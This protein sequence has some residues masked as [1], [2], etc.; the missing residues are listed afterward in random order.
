MNW[1]TVAP[2]LDQFLNY[3]RSW[4]RSDV[5]A[6]L[7][8]AA[9]MVP[10]VMANATIAGLSPVVGLWASLLP[11]LVYAALGTSRLLS[12]GPDSTLALMTASALAPWAAGDPA[13]YAVL[14]AMLAILVGVFCLLGGL[15]KLGVLSDLLSRPVLVGFMTGV[16]CIMISS[17]FGKLTGAPVEGESF[18][19]QVWSL[20]EKHRQMHWPTLVMAMAILAALLLM[21]R[22]FPRF[23]GALIVVL[24]ST[25]IVAVF[26]LEKYGINV[27]GYV[28]AGLPS[29][30]F[31]AVS[32]HELQVLAGAA[33]GLSIV[34]FSETSLTARIFSAKNREVV[35]PNAELRALGV[36]NLAAGLT[37]GLA[38]GS[39]SSRTALAASTGARSQMFSLFALIGILVVIL[40]ANR[41][42]EAFPVAALGALVVYAALYL[43][44]LTEIKRLARFRH[45]ELVLCLLTTLGVLTLG[46]LYGVL[47]AIGL[48]ILD[49]LR[50]VARPHDSVQG[51]VPGLAGMHDIDDYPEAELEPGLL[52]YR[53]DARLMFANA[54]D[55]VRRALRSVDE[56]PH[57]VKWFVLNAEAIVDVDMTGLDALVRLQEELNLRGIVFAMARVKQDLWAL[58]KN[59][60]VLREIEEDYIFPT[61]PTAV[62]A[63]RE[64]NPV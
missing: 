32:L 48:S 6:G 52:V 27:V 34:A 51:F 24:V 61:L 59:T 39:S 12:A 63:Y 42:L 26:S 18:F 2:G 38:V 36:C 3:K 58:L 23:P 11:I 55:F 4:L 22:F 21:R 64:R 10:Q 37:Q 49:L 7:T 45:S 56:N 31:P 5:A 35:D 19:E 30:S 20:F 43:V 40:G 46:V 57:P 44:D 41:V 50:R 60:H 13:K 8:V 17:Q 47:A 9:Y 1:T 25:V 54:E 53:Y 29:L 62:A 33:V 14:A 15:F 16:A 28:P